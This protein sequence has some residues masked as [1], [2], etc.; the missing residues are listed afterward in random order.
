MK[1]FLFLSAFT[2]CLTLGIIVSCTPTDNDDQTG[3]YTCHCVITTTSGTNTAD[4]PY[5]NVTLSYAT[6]TCATQQST[7]TSTGVT[8]TCTLQ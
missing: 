3:N 1:K 4:Q 5:T 2:A 6:S 8:A 7:Y